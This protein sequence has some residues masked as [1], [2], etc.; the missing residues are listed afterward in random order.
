VIDTADY[1]YF[2]NNLATLYKQYGRRFLV[3]KNE[4]VIGTYNSFDDAFNETTKT[5]KLGT[6]LTQECV[7]NPEDLILTFQG[8]VAFAR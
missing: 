7:E 2:T 4:Q 3:I 6:F 5:E 1:D 8:N